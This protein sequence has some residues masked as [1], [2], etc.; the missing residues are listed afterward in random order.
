VTLT[1]S[2]RLHYEF[3]LIYVDTIRSSHI[4]NVSEKFLRREQEG[5]LLSVITTGCGMEYTGMVG[6]RCV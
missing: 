3:L 1:P 5:C 6:G 2:H 4:F